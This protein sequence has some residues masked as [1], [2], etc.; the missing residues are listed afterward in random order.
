MPYLNQT[1]K[2]K[3]PVELDRRIKLNDVQ[4]QEIIDLYRTTIT[5]Q[6]KLAKLYGVSRRLIYFILNPDKL[7]ECKQRR[8]EKGTTYYDKEKHRVYMQEH[9]TYRQKLYLEN[10]LEE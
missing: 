7:E 10:K 1:K 4:K 8:L 5:S 3:I 6:R 2:L 9:R